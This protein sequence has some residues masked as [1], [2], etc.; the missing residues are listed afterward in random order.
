M[1][2]HLKPKPYVGMKVW[3]RPNPLEISGKIYPSETV[4]MSHGG[5]H[6]L[7][8]TVIGIWSDREVNLLV[9]DV[10]GR[11]FFRPKAILVQDGDHKPEDDRHFIC[12][13]VNESRKTLPRDEPLPGLM[14]KFHDAEHPLKAG[15]VP[16][17][18]NGVTIKAP[19]VTVTVTGTVEVQHQP[20]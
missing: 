6:P 20:V 14:F 8:A 18:N 11:Q 15:I 3:Y 10:L 16:L 5:E 7:D 1:S 4:S 12:E 2:N 9:T 17:D 19:S 13:P